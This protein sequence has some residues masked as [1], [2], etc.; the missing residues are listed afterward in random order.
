MST[1]TNKHTQKEISLAS[2]I[3]HELYFQGM[4]TPEQDG[5]LEDAM[6]ILTAEKLID[7]NGNWIYEN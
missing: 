7:S 2:S 3:Y 4:L 6:E 1:T 5:M